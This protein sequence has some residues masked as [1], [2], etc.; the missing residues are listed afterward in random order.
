VAR[1]PRKGA[2]IVQPPLGGHGAQGRVAAGGKASAKRAAVPAERHGQTA[3]IATSV[4]AE[5]IK[6]CTSLASAVRYLD[7]DAQASRRG[8]LCL[9]AS[10]ARGRRVLV[11]ACDHAFARNVERKFSAWSLQRPS[12]HREFTL[13]PG[14]HA[15]PMGRRVPGQVCCRPTRYYAIES[16]PRRRRVPPTAFVCD[17]AGRMI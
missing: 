11:S 7:R 17:A 15:Q 1:K 10:T 9:P 16:R 12:R 2:R 3:R 8:K 6:L 13:P 14:N 5:N 4:P